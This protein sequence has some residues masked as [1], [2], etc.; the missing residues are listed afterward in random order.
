MFPGDF[1]IAGEGYVRKL[2][3]NILRKL[4]FEG[5]ESREARILSS[6]DSSDWTF[7][8]SRAEKDSPADLGDLVGRAQAAGATRV[9]YRWS[10]ESHLSMPGDGT[11]VLRRIAQE[12]ADYAASLPP[13]VWA[14]WEEE[15]GEYTKGMRKKG[16]SPSARLYCVTEVVQA[17]LSYVFLNSSGAA[18]DLSVAGIGAVGKG[19]SVHGEWIGYSEPLAIA[20]D[21]IPF[22]PKIIEKLIKGRP[23]YADLGGTYWEGGLVRDGAPYPRPEGP[24][25]WELKLWFPDS[26]QPGQEV[27]ICFDGRPCQ[28]TLRFAVDAANRSYV[29]LVC[30]EPGYEAV[31]CDLI[32]IESSSMDVV[33]YENP[34]RFFNSTPGRLLRRK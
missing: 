23:S 26:I 7:D 1:V 28:K 30:K 16:A 24:E 34:S 29:H 33:M 2:P 12:A 9:V 17:K 10:E 20:W 5:P 11:Q 31:S 14:S 19:N 3:G 32:A 8:I 15:L 18:I 6:M 13:E 4:G 22:D 21:G 27:R 25:D